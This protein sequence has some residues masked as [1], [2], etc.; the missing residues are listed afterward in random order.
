MQRRKGAGNTFPLAQVVRHLTQQSYGC[1]AYIIICYFPCFRKE[2]VLDFYTLVNLHYEIAQHPKTKGFPDVLFA[3][4]NDGICRVRFEENPA[5]HCC[6][7]R[8]CLPEDLHL[9]LPVSSYFE[10]KLGGNT[11]ET[12]SPSA[13]CGNSHPAWCTSNTGVGLLIRLYQ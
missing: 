13:Y 6:F 8:S 3:L 9:F 2:I 11:N 12:N 7:L 10:K 5:R 1:T 4:P